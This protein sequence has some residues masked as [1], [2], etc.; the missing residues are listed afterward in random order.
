MKNSNL[1][2]Y[3]F[4][5]ITKY[6]FTNKDIGPNP[7]PPPNPSPNPDTINGNIVIIDN[8]IYECPPACLKCSQRTKCTNCMPGY[9]IENTTNLCLSCINCATCKSS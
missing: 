9:V 6:N 4:I 8:I 1:T 5:R 7:N 2:F 3:E